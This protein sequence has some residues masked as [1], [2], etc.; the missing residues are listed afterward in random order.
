MSAPARPWVL[1]GRGMRLSGSVS[2]MVPGLSHAVLP[3]APFLPAHLTAL[4]CGYRARPGPAL[5]FATSCGP[6]LA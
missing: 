2:G 6:G 4:R 1:V 5:A 3:P